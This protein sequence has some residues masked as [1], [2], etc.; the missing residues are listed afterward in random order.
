VSGRFGI[1][2]AA[3]LTILFLLEAATVSMPLSKK[4]DW[5]ARLAAKESMIPADVPNDTVLLF[6][7]SEKPYY[8]AELDAMIAAQ[9]RGLPTLNG[10][11]GNIPVGFSDSFGTDLSELPRRVLAWVAFSDPPDQEKAYFDLLQRVLPLGFR[12]EPSEEVWSAAKPSR[13]VA[14]EPYS[15]SQLAGLS[16]RL[17]GPEV[18][19]GQCLLAVEVANSGTLD[20][21]AISP[22][23]HHIMLSWRFVDQNGS[24]IGGWD[25]RQQI[26]FDIPVRGAITMELPIGSINDCIG[27]TVE[28]SL[29]QEGKFWLHD[30]GL[31]PP[32]ISLQSI[33]TTDSLD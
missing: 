2:V 12:K 26:P 19:R 18:S 32:R 14:P 3:V 4:A 27:K 31:V 17:L 6:A 24:S 15:P 13:S 7:Q 16:I 11:T 5:Q 10:Y 25:A 9:R 28:V 20:I 29:V 1:W 33:S 22:S 23:R 8:A 21:A 30:H